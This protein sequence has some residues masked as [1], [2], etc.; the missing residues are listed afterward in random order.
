MINQHFHDKIQDHYAVLIVSNGEDNENVLG[1]YQGSTQLGGTS[2]LVFSP[3]TVIND[4]E[5]D[6][7][8]KAREGYVTRKDLLESLENQSD[9]G[10]YLV[11]NDAQRIVSL[12][13]LEDLTSTHVLA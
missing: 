12:C 3:Y 10:A 7:I 9:N 2:Y 8:F 1:R 6:E 11:P 5:L 4:D 13:F